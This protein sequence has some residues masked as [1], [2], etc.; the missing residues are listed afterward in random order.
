[1]VR[2]GGGQDI[3][4]DLNTATSKGSEPSTPDKVEQ[5]STLRS[6]LNAQASADNIVPVA[7]EPSAGRYSPT[8]GLEQ[9]PHHNNSRLG[10]ALA[11][12]FERSHVN[13]AIS[14][15]PTPRPADFI[16][17]LKD[18]D[19]SI[20]PSKE[21]DVSKASKKT[22]SEEV[23][24]PDPEVVLNTFLTSIAD[25]TEVKPFNLDE[26]TSLSKFDLKP[27]KRESRLALTDELI[28]GLEKG[29]YS[30]TKSLEVLSKW[31]DSS[32]GQND[33]VSDIAQALDFVN[34]DEDDFDFEL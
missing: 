26:L 7:A 27:I 6:N 29:D 3:K 21:A 32:L 11:I 5:G 2:I 25:G 13:D 17:T 30:D 23:K 15:T 18:Y 31:K 33:R 8:V 20:A 1:M 9:A 4:V 12:V 22:D 10:D 16:E 19:E 24:L 14:S 28:R 34:S